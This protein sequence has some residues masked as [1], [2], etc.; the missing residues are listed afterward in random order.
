MRFSQMG[1][2]LVD[3]SWSVEMGDWYRNGG[4][5]LRFSQKNY[6]FVEDMATGDFKPLPVMASHTKV[7]ISI[8][9]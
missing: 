2:W 7:D 3:A 9:L 5:N 6:K 8:N 4:C 1:L